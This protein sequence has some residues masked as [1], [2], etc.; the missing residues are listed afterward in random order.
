MYRS[1]EMIDTWNNYLI[2]P[3]CDIWALGCILYTLCFMSHPFSDSAK[4]KI[5]NANFT[6]PS[7]DN[8]YSAFHDIIRKYSKILSF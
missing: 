3:P 7:G 2:G 8:K 1:P 4:L 5:L 6:I